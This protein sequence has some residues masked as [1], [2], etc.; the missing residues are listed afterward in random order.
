MNK[1]KLFCFPYAGGAAIIYENWRQFSNLRI[2]VK[3]VELA[4][5][6]KR[7]N[8]TPYDSLEEAVEDLFQIIIEEIKEHDYAFFGHSMGSTIAYELALKIKELN[9]RQPKHLFFSGKGA[10]DVK[11]KKDKKYHLL[12]EVQFKKKILKLGGTPEEFFEHPDLL[13]LFIPILRNDFK[14]A[15]TSFETRKLSP[16]ECEISILLGKD[17]EISAEQVYGWRN[18]T[19]KTCS[20]YFFNGNHFF[21]NHEGKELF[22]VIKNSLQPK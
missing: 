20:I 4:G 17:E 14:L 3:P 7:F 19:N 2:E 5:H 1:I 13:E 16:F 10:P 6:G 22:R 15:S 12:D 11:E 21:L 9:V 18:H 8:D